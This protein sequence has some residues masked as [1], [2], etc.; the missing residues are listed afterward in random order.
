MLINRQFLALIG[1]GTVVL[2][3]CTS[4]SPTSG[5]LP[6]GPPPIDPVQALSLQPASAAALPNQ[7]IQFQAYLGD[8]PASP[9]QIVWRVA[10]TSFGRIAQSGQF[11]AVRCY[12][13]GTTFVQA[14]LAR[15]TAKHASAGIMVFVP[16]TALVQI[17]A[18]NR[19]TDHQPVDL[20]RVAGSIEVIVN[21]G[22]AVLC[23]E[24]TSI[25]LV[26]S[27]PFGDAVV[28]EQNWAPGLTESAVITLLWDTTLASN[29]AAFPN[30]DYSIV[31]IIH[32]TR[33]VREESN[34]IPLRVAN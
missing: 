7:T 3:G 5:T 27:G 13:G 29:G 15:D 23:T 28:A 21:I 6:P 30:G 18:I 22:P 2:V 4:P 32:G 8:Q 12:Q 14:T 17:Q 20:G 24:T 11:T 16:G 31:A 9:D 33:Q 26:V 34:R 1:I 10:D 25:Q 19:A